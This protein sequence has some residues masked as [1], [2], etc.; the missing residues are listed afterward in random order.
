MWELIRA[1]KRK[2]V[3]LFMLMGTLLILLGYVIGE[4]YLPGEGGLAGLLIAVAIWVAWSMIAYF[5]G[6]SIL[7]RLSHAREVTHDVHPQLFN[8]VEEMKI[9][10]NLKAMPKI[11]II[12]EE[13]PNA[14]ATGTRPDR[15]AI[16]V[17][18]GLLSRLNRNELQG[19]V[20]HE[21]S[22]ILNRDVVFVTFAGVML[23]TIVMISEIF[24]RSLWYGA[25]VGGR[26]RSRRSSSKGGGGGA[27]LIIAIVLAILVP[28][29]TRLFYFAI[30]RKREYLADASAVR[31]TR[32]PE[33]L[34]SALEKI[35]ASPVKFSRIN[36]ITAPMYIDT[37][38]RKKGRALSGLFRTH[39]PSG[40]RIKILRSMAHGVNF[41]QYQAAYK[42]VTGDGIMPGSA[43]KD[44]NTVGIRKPPGKE[45]TP[46]SPR[47]QKRELG[48][49]MRAVNGYV[50]LTC[51]CGLKMKLPPGFK[52]PK[53][54]CPRCKR[55]IQ[56][57]LAKLAAI[58]AAVAA[59]TGK[60]DKPAPESAAHAPRRDEGPLE[61]VRRGSGWETVN[62]TC[63]NHLTL[64]PYFMGNQ[65]TCTKC[66][67]RTHIKSA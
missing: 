54:D 22:H 25:A 1:N 9:A 44:R 63:G 14:F 33:G 3:I 19:V 66:G 67:R 55:T 17:T 27:L 2:S 37:P 38:L 51:L 52:D 45:E 65:L 12:D 61:Y 48:D 36:S 46:A 18:A 43:L 58:T 50:F 49:L 11:Y 28:I 64:S 13:A 23:G 32:Y 47:Q 57:P 59:G 35:S 41:T 26:Y 24:L 15:C 29:L 31:L 56:V 30:S 7:L 6:D 5:S 42:K 53:V 10:A 16:A 39:P 40:Q 4:A 20:A 8:V 62:C 34:A 60:K 21:M